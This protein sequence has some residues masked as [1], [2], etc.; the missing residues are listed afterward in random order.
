[1]G[2]KRKRSNSVND[3]I[4]HQAG[5]KAEE[6]L[7]I[8]LQQEKPF[9]AQTVHI[10]VTASCQIFRKMRKPAYFFACTAAKI[11]TLIHQ[12]KNKMRRSRT[13]LLIA[14]LGLS[15]ATLASEFLFSFPAEKV[16][17]TKAAASQGSLA[18][19]AV[20][21]SN[22]IEQRL[23]KGKTLSLSLPG[24]RYIDSEIR[25]ILP[26]AGLIH[27]APID[28]TRIA[29]LKSGHGSVEIYLQDGTITGML[30]LDMSRNEVFRARFDASGAGVLIQENPD[31]YYCVRYPAV[32]PA[33][34]DAAPE[35]A[36]TA[37]IPD[38]ETLKHLQS[39]PGVANILYINY[40]GGSYTGTAWNNGN[41]IDYTPFSQ[42]SDTANFSD[43]ERHDMWLAWAETAEDYAP[44]NINVTTDADVYAATPENQRVQIIATTTSDWYG[45]AGGVAYVGIFGWGDQYGTGWV[46]NKGPSSLGMTISHESG[47]QMG[48][49]HDGNPT[50][51]Y[52]SGHGSWGPIMGGPFGRS[53][54]QWSKGEY[55]DAV[56][57]KDDGI[58]ED[59]LVI[60]RSAV[61]E[62]ADEAGD[63]SASA[64]QLALPVIEKTGILRPEGL[65]KDIDVYSFDLSS[66]ASVKV[67]IGPPLGIQGESMGTSLSLNAQLVDEAGGVISSLSPSSPPPSNVLQETLSLDAGR[68]E[69]ILKPLSYDPN[70]NTG[71]GEYANGGYYS[72]TIEKERGPD[73]VTSAK[74]TNR[75]IIS[76]GQDV[77]LVATISNRGDIE[78]SATTLRY[79][80]ADSP[81]VTQ[82]NLEAPETQ[83]IDALTPG[84]AIDIPQSLAISPNLSAGHHWVAGC[85]DP[86]SG[87]SQT[88]NNCSKGVEV[89]IA[90]GTCDAAKFSV[91]Q[92]RYADY[93]FL[94]SETAVFVSDS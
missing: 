7:S 20:Q 79:Y 77:T 35:I 86:V 59:D 24:N 50:H 9:V 28:E 70:W 23:E 32:I 21:L 27:D 48:L 78:A 6:S 2:M 88:T 40:W 87:E 76:P 10:Q 42:D 52:E 16:D 39:K 91:N 1:M 80:V 45:N 46:W 18:K 34:Q 17:N 53:Y 60:I 65:G 54:A 64:V 11:V 68:Y 5:R 84:A 14:L 66:P 30:V 82:N 44:F 57:K 41:T 73:L 3:G 89:V 38:L 93:H 49:H 19:W 71:F 69:L 13:V 31:E 67:R 43:Q 83:Q 29:N 55:P 74:I 58:Q 85:V 22:G 36:N 12:E 90:T 81:S 15:T 72:I 26:H 8:L 56:I 63:S 75:Q 25:E 51:E 61:G 92:Q 47:H 62:F 37:P 4:F 94:K 33:T